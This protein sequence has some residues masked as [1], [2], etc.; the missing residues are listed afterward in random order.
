[1]MKISG[2]TIKWWKP[3]SKIRREKPLKCNIQY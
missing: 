3:V 2:G 1:M